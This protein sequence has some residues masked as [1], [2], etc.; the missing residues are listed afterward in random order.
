[1]I[2]RILL[3]MGCNSFFAKLSSRI[4]YNTTLLSITVY[5]STTSAYVIFIKTR[6]ED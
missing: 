2:G 1:M 3:M 6:V 4:V 5:V